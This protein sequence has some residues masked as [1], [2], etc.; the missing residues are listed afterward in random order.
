MG[1]V[2]YE[3]GLDDGEVGVDN[4]SSG[5]RFLTLKQHQ[6]VNERKRD[7]PVGDVREEVS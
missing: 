1:V 3:F 6:S 2:F 7:S 4:G 5:C